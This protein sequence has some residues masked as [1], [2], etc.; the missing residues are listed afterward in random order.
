MGAIHMK[1]KVEEV[2][3]LWGLESEAKQIYATAWSIGD[4]YVL[5]T[6]EDLKALRRNITIMKVL[7]ECGIPVPVLI[8]TI[9]GREYVEEAGRYYLVMNK[10]KGTHIT[11]LYI[12][13]YTY[14]AYETGKVIARLHKAFLVCEQKVTFGENS[15]LEEMKGWIKE[16][17]ER[18]EFKYILQ[19]NF[20]E[21]LEELEQHYAQLPKQLIHR[22]IHYGNLLFKETELSGYIDFDLCEKNIRLFDICYFL[23]GI[24]GGHEKDEEDIER[25]LHIVTNLIQGYEEI[26]PLTVLEKESMCCVMKSIELLFVAYFLNETNETLAKSAASMHNFVRDYEKE[27]KAAI[28]N[29]TK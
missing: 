5:K 26:V 29:A 22:D 8:P 10:L 24:L 28:W 14:I 11:D 13:D 25:W 16:S 9:D 12:R 7:D 1:E 2:L 21:N 20:K 3:K 4:G 6:G 15:L 18:H 23:M 17:L 19:S 27:I